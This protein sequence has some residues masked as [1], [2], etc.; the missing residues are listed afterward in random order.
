VGDLGCRYQIFLW[1]TPPHG[2]G[3]SIGAIIHHR[4][5]TSCLTQGEREGITSSTGPYH[6]DI[7]LYH[8]MPPVNRVSVSALRLKIHDTLVWKP[9][10]YLFH[11]INLVSD[12][13]D[14]IE[15]GFNFVDVLLLCPSI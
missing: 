9:S 10:V 6:Q 5:L 11:E 2:A 3:P 13:L 15:L 1:L 8:V 7:Y 4:D 14:L 12:L